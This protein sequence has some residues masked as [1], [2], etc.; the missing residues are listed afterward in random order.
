MRIYVRKTD[1]VKAQTD[2]IYRVAK[3]LDEGKSVCSV[4]ILFKIQRRSLARYVE[5]K[6]KSGLEEQ[7]SLNSVSPT[8]HGQFPATAI[9]FHPSLSF[10]GY[11]HYF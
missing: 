3:V 1:R 7:N 4:A 10:L 11:L 8:H 2:V 9:L 5:N 6:K